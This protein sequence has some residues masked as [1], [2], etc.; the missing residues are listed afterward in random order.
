MARISAIILVMGMC[1]PETVLAWV[2][3]GLLLGPMTGGTIPP[4]RHGVGSLTFLKEQ[5]QTQF[6]S[7]LSLQYWI[8]AV[9]IPNLVREEALG[10]AT[11]S[12]IGWL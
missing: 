11:F 3:W 9:P 7:D 10:I 5:P 12:R 6:T 8:G 4:G 1:M 2:T